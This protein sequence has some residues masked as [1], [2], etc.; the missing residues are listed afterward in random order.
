MAA[1]VGRLHKSSSFGECHQAWPPRLF[2][3]TR[4]FRMRAPGE[5]EMTNGDL[6]GILNLPGDLVSALTA[7]SLVGLITATS[8]AVVFKVTSDRVTHA[9][10]ATSWVSPFILSR[11]K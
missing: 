2:E 11:N 8:V 6:G 1:A 9:V 10:P 7:L 5:G 4:S 3:G